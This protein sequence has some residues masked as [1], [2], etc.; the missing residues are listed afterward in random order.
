VGAGQ[1]PEVQEAS[2]IGQ[3][4]SH[5]NVKRKLTFS[6]AVTSRFCTADPPHS[7]LTPYY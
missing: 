6:E 7:S 2:L 5:G 3:Y 1:A 4:S